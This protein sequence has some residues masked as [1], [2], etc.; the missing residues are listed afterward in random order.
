MSVAELKSGYEPCSL[1]GGD[2]WIMVREGSDL[3]RPEYK[4]RFQLTRCVS[5]GHVMQ[6]PKPDARE[7]NAAYSISS[8]YT[9]YRSAWKESGWP[10]WKILRTWT[11]HR[12]ILWL[13]RYG[14]GQEILDVGCGAGDFMVASHRV[15]WN[16]RAVDY[17]S[18][19]VEMISGELGFDVR[20]GE[21]VLG[22]WK[23]NQFDVITFWNVLE[24]FQDPMRELSIAALYLRPG[25]R[26]LFQFPSRQAAE[27]G[28]WFGQYWAILDL[29]RHLH[30][31]N[32]STFS[33]L[34]KKAGFDLIVY[35]TPFVQSAWCYYMSSWQW[36]KQ[37]ERRGFG[38]LRF[39]ILAAA[40][41]LG[42]PYI[43][44]QT[45]R[46][47]GLEVFAVAVKR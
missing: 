23:E 20:A 24:H 14:K 3:C 26:V 2:E 27:H 46:K 5:C 10:I 41:T 30:F 18:S 31:Y 32:E 28:L 16:V 17:N 9:S 40:V 11:I 12:R 44:L 42:L 35:K 29:P 22:L 38:W 8:R 39:L 19:I 4:K 43:V 21:L 6:N 36:A 15:G 37:V 33:G 13:K 34:C 7:L 45:M 1:C 25:G 47:R